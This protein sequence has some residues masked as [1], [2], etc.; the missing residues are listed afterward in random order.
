MIDPKPE[1][2]G[3]RETYNVPVRFYGG[4][5]LNADAAELRWLMQ[6][7]RV[8]IADGIRRGVIPP[9]I[10]KRSKKVRPLK[11]RG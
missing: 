9:P 8:L 6:N 1:R 2:G 10:R 4:R 11:K 7:L 5:D 3:P